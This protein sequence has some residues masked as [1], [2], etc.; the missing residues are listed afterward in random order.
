MHISKLI[1]LE[2]I[3]LHDV[4]TYDSSIFYSL[5][6]A[7]CSFIMQIGGN[8]KWWHT[9]RLEILLLWKWFLEKCL[10]GLVAMTRGCL[11]RFWW[12]FA[13]SSRLELGEG[14]GWTLN[15]FSFFFLISI[16]QERLNW[17]G[18]IW[19]WVVHLFLLVSGRYYLKGLHDYL[20]FLF[21]LQPWLLPG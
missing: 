8:I 4:L 21:L 16:N 19:C 9:L 20:D 2:S 7:L 11:G 17:R 18:C 12:S 3:M 6:V 15:G 5:L 10:L 13:Q 14:G 1:I